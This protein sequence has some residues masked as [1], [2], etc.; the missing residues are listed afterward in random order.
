MF[1]FISPH[2]NSIRVW[3]YPYIKELRK[4]TATQ[5]DITELVIIL[6]ES[7]LYVY[8]DLFWQ[9]KRDL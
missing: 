5:Q 1:K 8:E 2:L 3:L 7:C 6:A 9:K 4:T